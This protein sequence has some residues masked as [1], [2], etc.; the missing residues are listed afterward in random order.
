MPL[1]SPQRIFEWEEICQSASTV[2]AG[3]AWRV[4]LRFHRAVASSPWR[5]TAAIDSL[6]LDL[7]DR[8]RFDWHAYLAGHPNGR[9]VV[10]GGVTK[11]ELRYTDDAASWSRRRVCFVAHRVDPQ[12]PRARLQPHTRQSSRRGMSRTEALPVY[13]GNMADWAGDRLR[14]RRGD[15]TLVA[16][17]AGVSAG[18]LVPTQAAVDAATFPDGRVKIY[19][20]EAL[21]FLGELNT[22]GDTRWF[23]DLTDDAMR[24]P[25]PWRLYL[26]SSRKLQV[27]GCLQNWRG[28]LPP[29]LVSAQGM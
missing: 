24:F 14:Q 8:R 27:D 18:A 2:T 7:T 17:G 6:S 5:E 16:E 29:I 12:Y 10:G 28:L 23:I 11:F 4:A 26:Q 19:N 13:Y 25:F 3:M 15:G 22:S 1:L 20:R 9:E 21:H